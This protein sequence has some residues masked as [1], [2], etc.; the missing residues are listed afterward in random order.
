M[1]ILKDHSFIG[2]KVLSLL[3]FHVVYLSAIYR[4]P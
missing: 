2:R 4:E 3:S 1:M